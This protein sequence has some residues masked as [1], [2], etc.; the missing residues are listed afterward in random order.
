MAETK[1]TKGVE[2]E[3]YGFYVPED[4]EAAK[5]MEGKEWNHRKLK[6]V[7]VNDYILSYQELIEMRF[8]YQSQQED[9]ERD[10]EILLEKVEATKKRIEEYKGKVKEWDEEIAQAEKD[11][12]ELGER[13][14]IDRKQ[15]DA[16]KAK[17]EANLRGEGE[18]RAL[19]M[20]EAGDLEDVTGSKA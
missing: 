11:I 20:N 5:A 9:A 12:P 3:K 8:I 18:G 19:E 10:L 16:A 7:I 14:A 1:K 17:H 15:A 2:I 4:P 13:A 6:K